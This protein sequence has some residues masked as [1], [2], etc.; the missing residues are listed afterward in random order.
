MRY[1]QSVSAIWRIDDKIADCVTSEGWNGLLTRYFFEMLSVNSVFIP[2][3]TNERLYLSYGNFSE[4]TWRHPAAYSLV[5]RGSSFKSSKPT[6]YDTLSPSNLLLN[7][8]NKP[9]LLKTTVSY[10]LLVR[11]LQRYKLAQANAD[12]PCRWESQAHEDFTW[13]KSLSGRLHCLRVP[14][15]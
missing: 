15:V 10:T 7:G 8:V 2:V 14:W 5:T 12:K 6:Y 4:K 3:I 9:R 1:N 11:Y 13:V